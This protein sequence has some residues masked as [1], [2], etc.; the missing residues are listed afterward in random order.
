MI[1][2]ELDMTLDK[3]LDVSPQL[4]SAY[5]SDDAGAAAHRHVPLLEG[6]PRHAAPTRRAC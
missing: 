4:R 6:M 1:P 2:F 3:A 5:D